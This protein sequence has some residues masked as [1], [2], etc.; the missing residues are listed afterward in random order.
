[1]STQINAPQ[2]HFPCSN[3]DANQ[4]ELGAIH[5]FSCDIEPN[6]LARSKNGVVKFPARVTSAMELR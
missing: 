1:M 6:D 3:T 4:K 2:N 5:S